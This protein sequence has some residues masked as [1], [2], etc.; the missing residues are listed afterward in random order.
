[1]GRGMGGTG[2][3]IQN[4]L[5]N[6]PRRGRRTRRAQGVAWMAAAPK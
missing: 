3:N 6:M 4:L 5:E 1:M 2:V